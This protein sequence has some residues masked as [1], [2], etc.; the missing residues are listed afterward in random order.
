MD[1]EA[2]KRE[3]P[4]RKPEGEDD[5]KAEWEGSCHCGKVHYL[6]GR[7]KP[8]ASKYCHCKDCQT[9]H[10]AAFQWATIFHKSDLRFTNGTEGLA[11]YSST[12][13]QPV[14]S[15]PCKVYC[16]T[17]HT[18]IM[19][20]GRNMIMLFPELLKGLRGTEEGREGFRVR[21]HICWPGRVVDE[22]VFEGD[23]VRKWAGVDG[24]SELLDDGNGKA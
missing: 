8:L 10:A 9:M 6:L 23:G 15:T 17:C 7:A 21:E 1:D 22:G 12:L 3:H 11:Y 5:F 19:D 20:E 18:P 14:H 2:W 4:Y 13:R 24:R 16:G